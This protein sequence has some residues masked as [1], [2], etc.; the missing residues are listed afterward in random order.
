M[1]FSQHQSIAMSVFLILTCLLLSSQT[2]IPLQTHPT[3]KSEQ[4]EESA[5]SAIWGFHAHRLINRMAVFTLPPAMMPLF[6]ENIDYL[7]EHAV[8]PD[9]RRYAV[10][11][12]A[13]RHYMDLD[14]W[15]VYP[16]PQLPREK[17]RALTRFAEVVMDLP[18][19]DSLLL[20]GD[21]TLQPDNRDSFLLLADST[22]ASLRKYGRFFRDQLQAA[23][24]DPGYAI[25]CDSVLAFFRLR[26]PCER[27]R[28]RDRLSP[29]GILPYH[30]LDMQRRLTD[31]FRDRDKGR[32]LKL[33]AEQGH[34]L[35]DAHV[36]L[37]TTSNYDGQMTGQKGIHAFW[38]SRIPELFAEEEFDFLV[39]KA[40]YLDDPAAFFWE[41]VLES[42]LL[43]KQ[44]LEIH[45]QTR[46]SFPALGQWCFEPRGENTVR[47][48]CRAYALAFR[49]RMGGMVERRMRAAIHA[50]GSA[51]Y[52]AWVDAGQPDLWKL[53][54]QAI[55]STAIFILEDIRVMSIRS[56]THE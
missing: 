10:S 17:F 22:Y 15:G 4:Y 19:Q 39:G 2:S 30:L 51:W 6:K 25:P 46:D 43:S 47:Q 9:K 7:A 56:R 45:R 12:E 33:A 34:Y 36:P 26:A 55:D 13:V 53:G 44:V 28:L 40:K 32:I 16:F 27:V 23:L 52:T 8:D 14:H 5:K 3:Q 54:G 18:G 37:H 31:A 49:T 21:E 38:E 20:V 1:V 41:V 29:H 11:Y 50:I 42:H 35:A 24:F 48:P